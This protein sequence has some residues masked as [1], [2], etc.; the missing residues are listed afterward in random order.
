MPS[1]RR[2]CP[3]RNLVVYDGILGPTP[4][5]CAIIVTKVKLK[6]PK[7]SKT[8][9]PIPSICWKQGVTSESDAPTCKKYAPVLYWK[10]PC[11]FWS[12]LLAC[13]APFSMVFLGSSLSSPK[14]GIAFGGWAYR[15]HGFVKKRIGKGT[16]KEKKRTGRGR[17]EQEMKEEEMKRKGGGKGREN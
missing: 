8:S 9:A 6:T 10:T 2:L 3:H 4:F 17:K 13:A 1:K 16:E 7:L 11:M 14:K 12:S 5:L 15:Y